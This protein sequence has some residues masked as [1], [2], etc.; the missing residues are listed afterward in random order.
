MI[1]SNYDLMNYDVECTPF[2]AFTNALCYSNSKATIIIEE[3]NYIQELFVNI[4][5]IQ[6]R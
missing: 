3:T 2:R 5:A 1:A 6:L 4:Y